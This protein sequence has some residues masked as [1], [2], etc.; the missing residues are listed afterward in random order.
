MSMRTV[1]RLV[2]FFVVAFT[3]YLGSTGTLIQLIDLRSLFTHAPAADPNVMAMREAFDGPGDYQVIATAD[4]IAQPLPAT[5]DLDALFATTVKGAHAALGDAPLRF[6]EVRMIDGKPLGQVRSGKPVLRFDPVTGAAL[7][8]A[9]PVRDDSHPASQRNTFKELHRMTTFGDLALWINIFVSIALATLIVTGSVM[10]VKLVLGRA[11]LDRK[12]L[13][14]AA[15]GWWKTLHRWVSVIA[16]AF[17]VVVTLSGSWLAMES[18]IFGY[19][20][21]AARSA[22]RVKQPDS[23]QP[24]KD[25]DLPAMLHT[26]LAAY[27]KAMPGVA[28]RVVRLRDYRGVP[29]GAVI[30][31]GEVARQLVFNA[32]TG[33]RVISNRFGWTTTPTFPFGWHAHQV[34]KSIHRGDFIGMS[35]RFMDLTA[36]LS[37]IYL[38]VSGVVMYWEMWRKRRRTGRKGLLWT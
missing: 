24:L 8:P 13:F 34:A 15:G 10:Y 3:L 20:M 16:V 1:H 7:G 38:S 31:D 23:S 21:T 25:A 33:E 12:G 2:T 26:T 9:P 35:G 37:M 32:V 27:H 17:L 11:K 22:P 28:A 19:R 4:H 6:V 30:S 14:W 5:A 29:Q 36:G 18:L